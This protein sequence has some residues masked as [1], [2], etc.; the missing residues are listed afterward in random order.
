MNLSHAGHSNGS[1]LYFTVHSA[2][3]TAS[4]RPHL[5]ASAVCLHARSDIEKRFP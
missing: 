5:R 2:Q 4:H 3:Y 1:P